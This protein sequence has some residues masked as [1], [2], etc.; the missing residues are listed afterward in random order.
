[1][2]K[3]VKQLVIASGYGKQPD[4]VYALT[5]DG[6]VYYLTKELDDEGQP[7]WVWREMGADFVSTGRQKGQDLSHFMP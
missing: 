7:R 1:M 3:P 2:K 5:E 4:A 6:E